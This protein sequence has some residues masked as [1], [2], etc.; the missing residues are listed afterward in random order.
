MLV[1]IV[2]YVGVT[3][4][5]PSTFFKTYHCLENFNMTTK[6]IPSELASLRERL[7]DMMH[8]IIIP[9]IIVNGE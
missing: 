6:M 9:I 7:R 2:V 1:N 3:S 4:C 8:N 5:C